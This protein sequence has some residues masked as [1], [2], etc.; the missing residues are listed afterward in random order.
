MLVI[1]RGD[2]LPKNDADAP[3]DSDATE[4]GSAAP[5]SGDVPTSMC[6]CDARTCARKLPYDDVDPMDVLRM[7][8]WGELGFLGMAEDAAEEGRLGSVDCE[9]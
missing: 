4:G 8:G 3:R 2:V 1:D 6:G 9:L 5:N 7:E